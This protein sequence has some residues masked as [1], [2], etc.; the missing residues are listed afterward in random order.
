MLAA[1]ATASKEGKGNK[2]FS[3]ID[4][5]WRAATLAA[6]W[7]QVK[8]RRGAAGI[9]GM[10]IARF[11]AQSAKYLAELSE[12]LRT[13]QY[14]AQAVRRT[15]IPKSDGGKRPLGIPAVKDRVV[16][17]A[18]K[19]V[20]EP[21]FDSAFS[22]SSYGFRPGRGCKDALREVDG[23]L[24]EGYT[25]VVDADLKSFFDTIP[26]E[27]LLARVA[28]RISDS[29]VLALIDG[30]LRQDIVHEMRRW[31][32]TGGTPQG[33]VI[34][35][36]LANIYLHPLDELLLQRGH[37]VV[38]YADDFV[39]LCPSAHEAQQALLVIQEWVR[40]NGLQ[41]NE[42]KTSIGDCRESG[43]GFEFL[44]YR[45]E[46]GR[47]WV[48]GKSI[49]KLKDAI[50]Q[51][52]RRTSGEALASIVSS[53]NAV[54]RGWFNYFK[55]AVASTFG[56]LDGMLRRRLRALLRK[57]EKRPSRG[58]SHA[59]S[60]RWPNSYFAHLGLFAM[61]PARTAASQPR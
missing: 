6:A 53:L 29:K 33:A 45:F 40:Q 8:A 13:G 12:Q 39:V 18:L 24:R 36:L 34:S 3:L 54:L 51:R 50:R 7:Q 38:R 14:R 5:V 16:Q 48:R 9:D 47:R 59:D 17:S 41:L 31:T 26:H 35:P 56:S 49:E 28:E 15:E 30:W 2:W 22:D 58:R 52:T 11:E 44:G 20:I 21:I 37:R 57:R 4:K 61:H 42:Q 19:R 27:R 23:L 60:R 1:L 46:A 32:P 10:S 43:Q 55:H 25:H